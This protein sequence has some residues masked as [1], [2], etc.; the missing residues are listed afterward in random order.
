MSLFPV[1]KLFECNAQFY[2][3]HN[4]NISNFHQIKIK[5]DNWFI[6]LNAHA[7]LLATIITTSNN[8]II[9]KLLYVILTLFQVSH[10]FSIVIYINAISNDFSCPLLYFSVTG[11]HSSIKKH[12][13]F[14]I[15]KKVI[16]VCSK[17]YKII[18]SPNQKF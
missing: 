11:P 15:T 18:F 5:Q 3:I 6:Q 7:I 14:Y 1:D 13:K 8:R 2:H 12:F 17:K 16:F 9:V 10:E 4:E